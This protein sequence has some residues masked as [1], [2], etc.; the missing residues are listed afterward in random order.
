MSLAWIRSTV[1]AR[2]AAA[3]ALSLTLVACSSK[4]TRPVTVGPSDPAGGTM[5]ASSAALLGRWEKIERSMP[6]I[7]LE[8]SVDAADRVTGRVWLSG[9]SY[10]APAVLTESTFVLGADRPTM[11]GELVADGRLRVHLLDAQGGVEH[12]ATMVKIP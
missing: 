1:L 6:P 4:E 9:V 3:A 2:T 7:T 11:R 10:D 8:L 12:E 5:L